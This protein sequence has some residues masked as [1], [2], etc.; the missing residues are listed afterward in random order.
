MDILFIR[1]YKYTT[2]NSVDDV[3]AD[4]KS[5]INRRWY[6]FSINMTGRFKSDNSFRV[7]PKWGLAVIRWIETSSAYL[8]GTLTSKENKTIIEVS[9]RPNSAFVL[10]FYL[11][12]ILFLVE[13][14]GHS[15]FVEGSKTF[16]LMIFPPFSLIFFGLIHFFTIRLRNWFERLLRIKRHE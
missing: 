6:D 4:I 8:N 3:R 12:I 9:I 14:F 11:M 13:L 1:R 16:S 5:I 2:H 7:A 10:L 15:M